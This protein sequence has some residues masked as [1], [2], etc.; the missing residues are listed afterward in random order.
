MLKK[1]EHRYDDILDLPRHISPKRPRMSVSDRAAQFSPFAAL[2]GHN[3]VIA[4]TARQTQARIELTEDMLRVL[5]EKLK[6]LDG[7]LPN[8]S[9]VTI[10]YFMQDEKKSGGS[11]IT[12]TGYINKI[13]KYKNIIITEDKT[14]IPVSDIVDIEG[15]IFN[16]WE[17]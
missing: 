3:A 14:V 12:K 6:I 1:D 7:V 16:K 10:T 11:Y 4:E 9:E 13:D 8:C 5:N 17:F 2:V 15:D